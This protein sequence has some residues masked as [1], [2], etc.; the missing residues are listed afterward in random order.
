MAKYFLNQEEYKRDQK[1]GHYQQK[2]LEKYKI[3]HDHDKAK[4]LVFKDWPEYKEL[5][6]RIEF[7]D[8]K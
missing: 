8:Y 1:F 6:G 5:F 2:F 4:E 3:T 7:P